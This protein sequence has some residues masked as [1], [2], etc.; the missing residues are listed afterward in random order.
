MKARMSRSS[1]SEQPVEHRR[2]LS[3]FSRN[4]S[5]MLGRRHDMEPEHGKVERDYMGRDPRPPEL[6]RSWPMRET[7]HEQ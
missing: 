7:H 4:A 3:A 6:H 5:A 2:S 1:D